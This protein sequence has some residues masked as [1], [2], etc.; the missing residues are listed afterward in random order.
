[1]MK[2]IA[3]VGSINLDYFIEADVLPGLGETVLGTR[4][5]TALGGKG[6]NQAVA[7]SRLGASVAFFGSIGN[8]EAGRKIREELIS[9]RVDLSG[10]NTAEGV[11]TGAAFIEVCRAQNKIIVIPGANALTNAAYV[12]AEAERLLEHDII[13]FQ[14]ETPIELIEYAVPLLF[15]AGKTII[16]NP[17]P[18]LEMKEE[19]IAMITYLTPNEHEYETVLGRK[20]RMEELLEL[21]PNKLIITCGEKGIRYHDGAGIVHIPVMP[22]TAVDTTGAGD[23]FSGAFAAALAEGKSLKEAI[24]YGNAAAGLSV[25]KKGAQAGMPAREEVLRHLKE[26]RPQ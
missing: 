12:K 5:F 8:D 7:A 10:L 23:T 13:L 21:L 15:R 20:A 16:V 14:L 2:K 22:V 4:F 6:A 17:A 19:L 9:E 24:E 1:M 18:A 3:V 25:R 26:E 11:Q